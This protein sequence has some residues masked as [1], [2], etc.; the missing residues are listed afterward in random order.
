MFYVA[1]LFVPK[2]GCR[3]VSPLVVLY[4]LQHQRCVPKAEKPVYNMAMAD[5][6][7]SCTS[8]DKGTRVSAVETGVDGHGIIGDFFLTIKINKTYWM[9]FMIH[10]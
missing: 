5:V 4:C 10:I 9:N 7:I 8:L 6:V 2:L 3:I 1:L